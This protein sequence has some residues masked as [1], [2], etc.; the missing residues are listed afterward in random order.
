MV[1]GNLNFNLYKKLNYFLIF[2]PLKNSSGHNVK[3]INLKSI[4]SKFLKLK[5]QS[6]FQVTNTG[7]DFLSRI[8][9]AQEIRS[10]IDTWDNI[11]P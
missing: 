10:E 2:D 7:K 11:P 1:P 8:P 9:V 4:I 3:D 6:I 5:V